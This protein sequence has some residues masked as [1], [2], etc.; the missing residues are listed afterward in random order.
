MF[1]REDQLV[2]NP[3][4]SK[5]E[6][7]FYLYDEVIEKGKSII[8]VFKKIIRV[9]QGIDIYFDVVLIHDSVC[10]ENIF[11]SCVECHSYL[12]LSFT[13]D[14]DERL[15]LDLN[16]DIVYSVE[17]SAD[18]LANCILPITVIDEKKEMEIQFSI[19]VRNKVYLKTDS[20]YE[21]KCEL[22]LEKEKNDYYEIGQKGLVLLWYSWRCLFL[23]IAF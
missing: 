2:D 12:R 21:R 4:L 16:E 6:A 23:T 7:Y 10:F 20:E 22:Y 1:Y 18:D 11:F 9:K 8:D 5:R 15:L 13:T 17:I 14:N 3:C 19:I